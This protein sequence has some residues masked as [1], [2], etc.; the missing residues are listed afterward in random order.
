MLQ[1][2]FTIGFT[3]KSAKLFFDMLKQNKIETVLDVRLNNTSQLAGFSKYPDIQ[4]FLHE[5]CAINY[6]SD[7]KF[8]PTEQILKDYKTKVITWDEYVVKFNEL[9]E[10][11]NIREYIKEMC[12]NMEISNICLLCSEANPTNCH[13]TLVA[14]IFKETLGGTIIHL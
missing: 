14:K 12:A 1:N 11:R 13:R 3:K 5:L 10:K 7:D 6:I 8:A 2:I 9:M 4:F